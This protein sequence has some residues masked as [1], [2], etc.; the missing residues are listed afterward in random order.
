MFNRIRGG[1]SPLPVAV[2]QSIEYIPEFNHNFYSSYIRVIITCNKN[3]SF[4]ACSY[5]EGYRCFATLKENN[6]PTGQ[7]NSQAGKTYTIDIAGSEPGDK[8]GFG[9]N[10]R[11]NF[12][13]DGV[14][15]YTT[16]Q[17]YSTGGAFS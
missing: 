1:G 6:S 12:L 5:T 16:D 10:D 14:V 7:V 11:I 4:T 13:A 3:F 17:A 8:R 2:V 9:F 15:F